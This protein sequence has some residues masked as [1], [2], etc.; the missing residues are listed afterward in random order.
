ML[1]LAHRGARRVAPEN[2]IEAFVAARR[3]G[4]DGVELDVHRMTDDGLV[5]HHDAEAAGFGVLAQHPL[6]EVLAALPSVPVLADVLDACR[7]LLVNVEIKNSP[8]DTDHDPTCRASDLVVDLL[9]RRGGSDHVIVSSFD[10]ATIDRVRVVGPD[11]PTG[12]LSFGLDPFDVLELARSRGHS[13]IHPDGPTLR[14]VAIEVVERARGFGV[15][16][17]TWT[18]NDP[19]MMLEFDA[20]GVGALITDVPDVALRTMG[21]EPGPPA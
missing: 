8:R 5:V 19:Q 7:G 12:F 2:T 16:V 4:A 3:Q 6:A 17:N 10:L 1:V 21:R 9:T 20:A 14:R 11:V 13:A 15:D 18:V